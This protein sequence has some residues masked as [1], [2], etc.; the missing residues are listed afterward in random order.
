MEEVKLYYDEKA[1]SYDEIFDMLYFKVYDEITWRYIEPY[2]PIDPNALVLDAGGGTGRWAIRMA[3]KGC[4]VILMDI[5]ERM[6][7]VVDKKVRETGLQHKITI[8][9]GDITKT[10]YANE[11]FDMILCEHTLFLFK[12]PDALIKELKRI[13][14]KKARLIISAQNRYVQSLA[15][16][17]EKP[18]SSKV[19]AAFKILLRQRYNAMTKDGKVKIYTWTPNEFRTMLERNGF[20]VEKIVGKGVTMPLRISKELFMKKDYPQDLFNKI[21]QFELTLCE[22]PDALALAGHLQAIAYKP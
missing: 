15:C 11:T 1:K 5:S 19:D 9:K 6:L 22:K 13:L 14:K 16:L 18:S 3:R 21:L 4:K 17:P 20:H 8:K 10:E 2:V 7:K 12:E